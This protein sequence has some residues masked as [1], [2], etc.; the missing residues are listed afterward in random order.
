MIKTFENFVNESFIENVFASVEAGIGAFKANKNADK[1]LNKEKD[2][3]LANISA[4]HNFS[5]ETK[6]TLLVKN[7]VEWAVLLADGCS[8]KKIQE[9]EEFKEMFML[10]LEAIEEITTELKELMKTEEVTRL[11]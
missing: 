10:R 11:A 9:D 4:N 2:F 3:A 5:D 8:W 6:L 1:A 7:M